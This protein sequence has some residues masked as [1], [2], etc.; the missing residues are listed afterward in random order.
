MITFPENISKTL[1]L[2]NY[3][4]QQPLVLRQA[5]DDA[6]QLITPEQLIELSLYEE[7][8]S[9]LLMENG[10]DEPWQV[11]HGPQE[12]DQI[13][14]LKDAQNWT[15]LV[16]SVN[17]WHKGCTQ[18]LENFA[19]I[20][21]W[22]LDDIMIS[23]ATESGS[24]GPHID[25][26]NVFLIQLCGTRRWIVG[27]PDA[28]VEF[29][30]PESGSQHI[31]PYKEKINTVLHPGDMLYLPPNTAHHGISIDP[32]MT[33]SV[34]FR[35]PALSEMMMIFAEQLMLN[36]QETYYSDPLLKSVGD[37]QSDDDAS[38]NESPSS[39]EIS[40]AA[41]AKAVNWATDLEQQDNLIRKSFGLLQTQPKQELLLSALDGPISEALES[42]Q[43]L[44]RDPAARVAWYQASEEIIWLFIN[45]ECYERPI[46]EKSAIQRI[47]RLQNLSSKK[48]DRYP[49]EMKLND[50]LEIFVDCG[51]FGIK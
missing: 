15:L 33:L 49:V 48:L 41:M 42:G 28:E 19:F 14:D 36:K 39:T 44:N 45:G 9:R 18:L 17:L 35:S 1:F 13:S 20:P 11:F 12:A 29:I 37:P 51:L 47:S 32:G 21:Q 5:M 43:K 38:Q 4:Q 6:E 25:H 10:P 50:L 16:Q 23:Y 46:A 8:E 31:K 3:W 22:R 27:E 7:V 2:K 40:A 24:V 26:Y 34:G 30:D